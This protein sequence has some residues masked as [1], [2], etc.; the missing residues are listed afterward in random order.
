MHGLP[1]TPRVPQAFF[2]LLGLSV[3]LSALLLPTLAEAQAPQKTLTSTAESG[4]KLT[5]RPQKKET[6]KDK[7]VRIKSGKKKKGKRGGQTQQRSS[8]QRSP[9]PVDHRGFFF[10][11]GA[12]PTVF[13]YGLDG[14]TDIDI[15]FLFNLSFGYAF[16]EQWGVSISGS[17][18]GFGF[19]DP[20]P[21]ETLQAAPPE[22]SSQKSDDKNASFVLTQL[23][24]DA[25]YFKQLSTGWVW[26]ARTGIG[27][28]FFYY[29]VPEK[30]PSAE[31][32]GQS[33]KDGGLGV[34]ATT[35]FAYGSGYFAFNMDL[36]W[37][38]FGV[39]GLTKRGE[40]DGIHALG[41][42]LSLLIR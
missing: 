37:R 23:T 35:G 2:S 22:Q 38:Y 29:D 33:L 17:A 20:K 42:T 26:H 10:D 1:P 3:G 28:G 11:F 12:G 21:A 18:G 9:G 7:E 34:L 6:K 4:G 24:L 31:G 15:G 39:E 30:Q 8:P 14:Q 41:L 5:D 16:T 32:E 36:G 40:V 25:H 19:A 27:G 13:F